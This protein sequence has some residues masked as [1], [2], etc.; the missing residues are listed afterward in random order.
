MPRSLVSFWKRV[1]TSGPTVD[2]RV[3]LPQELRDIAEPYL[4]NLLPLVDGEW[5]LFERIPARY[6]KQ[7]GILALDQREFAK[8]I[9]HFEPRKALT[10]EQAQQPPADTAGE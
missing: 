2:G 4:S 9:T 5:K 7:I 10:K 1:A 8:A 3:I 6:H